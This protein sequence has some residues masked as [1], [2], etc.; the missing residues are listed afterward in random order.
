[1]APKKKPAAKP[2]GTKKCRTKCESKCAGRSSAAK[3]HPYI[4]FSSR[5]HK[6]LKAKYPNFT[7]R[8]RAIGQMWRARTE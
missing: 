2:G 3:T 8:S 1:M 7:D 4:Q 5:M 6:Q